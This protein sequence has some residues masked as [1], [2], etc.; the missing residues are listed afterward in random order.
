MHAHHCP[1]RIVEKNDVYA[2]VLGC[3]VQGVSPD[4]VLSGLSCTLSGPGQEREPG[5]LP[6]AATGGRQPCRTARSQQQQLQAG[7]GCRQRSGICST[8]S[9]SLVP[10]GRLQSWEMPLRGC[11]RYSDGRRLKAAT[12][13]ALQNG[14]EP[15]AAAAGRRRLQAAQRHEQHAK[16][17]SRCLMGRRQSWKMPLLR[18][19]KRYSQGRRFVRAAAAG[20][21]AAR[22]A[23]GAGL[24]GSGMSAI[25]GN[26]V[27]AGLQALFQW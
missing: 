9:R 3:C 11:K 14:T 27:Y 18:Y 15:A 2:R 6:S 5:W 24:T 21:A 8:R 17:D 23:R 26:A 16:T 19:C 12:S 7:A 1:A 22:A 20:I 13:P 4:V 25:L 10:L